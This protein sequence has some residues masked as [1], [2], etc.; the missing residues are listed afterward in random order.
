M[1]EELVFCTLSTEGPVSEI[2]SSCLRGRPHPPLNPWHLEV[3]VGTRDPSKQL[4]GIVAFDS[5]LRQ[6]QSC[7]FGLPTIPLFLASELIEALRFNNLVI[8]LS[9]LSSN[10]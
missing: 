9:A 8:H 10:R 7:V 6:Q 2:E 3:F 1:G 4:H 5:E